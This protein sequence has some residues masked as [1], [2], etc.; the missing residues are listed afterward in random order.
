MYNTTSGSSSYGNTG[1]Q[2]FVGNVGKHRQLV[3][4][5]SGTEIATQTLADTLSTWT[6][7]INAAKSAR[8]FP[9]PKIVDLEVSDEGAVRQTTS[10]G[11]ASFVRE[12]KL[13]SKYMLEEMSIHN[14]NQLA[15][16]D[17]GSFDAYIVT[18][19]DWILGYSSDNA[20]FLPKQ[21]DYIKVLPESQ[22]TGT[23]NAHVSIEIQWT[24]AKQFNEL[25]VSTKP[26]GWYPSLQLSGVK[27]LIPVLS[28]VTATAFAFT[29]T[30]FDGV[31][32]S[33][34]VKDDIYLRKTTTTGTLIPITSV[35]ESGTVPGSYT[36][37][38]G[39]QT[40]GTF[41]FSLLDQ[42]TA[43]TNDVETPYSSSLVVTI[44]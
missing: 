35:T 31:P 13:V 32:Y 19:R 4:V 27:D 16:L 26:S 2:N 44:P 17:L 18:D 33:A 40:S 23:E 11:Y 37:V 34:A 36:G 12:G 7:N 20:K 24:D 43:P 25:E 3:L 28:S 30:G 5:P 41:Y 15:K 42:P 9:L 29:L 6:G 38:I 39:T 21:C 22:N 10:F 8:W 14:K 1:M